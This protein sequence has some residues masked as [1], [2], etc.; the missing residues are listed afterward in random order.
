MT[1]RAI[2]ANRGN[3]DRNP[4]GVGIDMF[5]TV[6]LAVLMFLFWILSFPVE[7]ILR[8]NFGER[9]YGV[10]GTIISILYFFVGGTLLQANDGQVFLIGIFCLFV[11]VRGL[12]HVYFIVKRNQKGIRWHSYAGGTSWDF[13][14]HW[15]ISHSKVQLYIE[16]LLC[17]SIGA[18]F[19]SLSYG[20]LTQ[21]IDYSDA[22]LE[23]LGFQAIIGGLALFGKGVII[24]Y[25]DRQAFLNTQDS[26]IESEMLEDVLVKQ[27]PPTETMGFTVAG[28]KPPTLRERHELMDMYKRLNPELQEMVS[29][30]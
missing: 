25:R 21:S 27:K 12:Y 7:I 11:A 14:K 17:I 1:N 8:S 28:A 13:W 29:S 20:E 4:S 22:N 26:K 10:Q 19:L 5:I 15:N 24:A 3:R 30:G 18:L 2:R 6:L 16:P 23:L 9:Y